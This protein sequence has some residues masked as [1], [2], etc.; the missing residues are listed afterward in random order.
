M[1]HPSANK[2]STDAAT[3]TKD[4]PTIVTSEPAPSSGSYTSYFSPATTT[5]H[6]DG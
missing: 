3:S 5:K 2:D 4:T 1:P 6:V